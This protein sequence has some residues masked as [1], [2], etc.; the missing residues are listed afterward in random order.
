M[1][2][3][4]LLAACTPKPTDGNTVEAGTGDSADTSTDTGT[5]TGAESE[6]DTGTETGIETGDDTS[7]DT[8]TD[9][10]PDPDDGE[11]RGVW[12]DRWTYSS[13]D[14]VRE[15]MTNIASAGFNTVFFQVRG[16]ADAYYASAFEPWA[17]RLSGRLGQDPGWD[18]LAVAVAEGHAR[19]LAVHA[20]I[21]AFPLW[22][23]TTLPTEST[24]RH[25]LLEHPDWLMADGS[26]T[27]MA[28]NDSYV[29][30]SPGNPAVRERLADVAEDIADHYD[31]DGIHLDLVRYPGADYSHDATSEALYDGSG[32]EDWQRAQVVEAIRGVHARVGIPVTAAVWGVYTNDWDWSGVSQGYTDYYQDSRAFLSEGVLD[33]TLPMVYWPVTDT[34][35]D[36]LD[37]STLV[38]DHVAHASGRYVFAGISAE[39]GEADVNRCIQSARDNGARGVVIF[40]YDLMNDAGWLQNLKTTAFGTP[41]TLPT[42]PWR[43]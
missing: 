5:D 32:W 10:S 18:P 8:S 4:L 6:V 12:V 7:T 43:H 27:P 35:G 21:N 17:S 40:D 37:F 33:A 14:D 22:A 2:L 26:G 36:R 9:T 28:L 42:Y 30:M 39:L 15:E 16:N 31:V 41:T 29:W 3:L 38:A 1:H 19:G 13:A 24:P 11:L 25:A 20:Y 23:G 34:P